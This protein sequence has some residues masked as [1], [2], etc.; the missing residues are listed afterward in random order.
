MEAYTF[1]DV[2]LLRKKSG[3]TYQ[4]AVALLE[5]H[6]GNLAKA[7]IDLEKNGKLQDSRSRAKTSAAAGAC[8]TGKPANRGGFGEFIRKMYRT[9]IKIHKGDTAV[10]NLSVLY[11]LPCLVFA[12]HITV[13]GVVAAMILGYRFSMSQMD[14]DFAEVSVKN[15][16]QQAQPEVVKKENVKEENAPEEAPVAN[17]SAA[18]LAA[19]LKED[20]EALAERDIP[21]IQ[22]PVQ[23][24]C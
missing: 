19:Q 12:P 13:F 15:P 2:E 10:V 14:A 6:N 21:T 9:R 5:Y 20:A 16:L 8:N 23:A 17:E 11:A 7:L 24:T 22:V 3:M 1:E 4:E 18:D